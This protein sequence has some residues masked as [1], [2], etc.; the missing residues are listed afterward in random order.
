[1]CLKPEAA[2]SPGE[3]LRRSPQGFTLL[4]VMV[5]LGIMAIVLVSVY[6]L[7]S[8]TLAMSVESRFYTQAPLLA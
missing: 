5:A 4:E 8:Q 2:D 7:H 6:R 3:R 1:M